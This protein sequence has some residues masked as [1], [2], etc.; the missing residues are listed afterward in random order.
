MVAI[1]RLSPHQLRPSEEQPECSSQYV[2]P[3][4]RTAGLSQCG[5]V[6]PAIRQE[7]AV[8]LDPAVRQKAADRL[9]PGCS[10]C[11]PLPLRGAW[12]GLVHVH[13]RSIK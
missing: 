1:I 10:S 8:H 13:G 11:L 4:K 5:A 12:E 6:D 9:D 7:S 3:L 2:P